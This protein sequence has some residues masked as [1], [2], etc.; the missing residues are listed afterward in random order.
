MQ[1]QTETIQTRPGYSI[2]L[3]AY[4]GDVTRAFWH[5]RR[6]EGSGFILFGGCLFW[7]LL[8]YVVLLWYAVKAV[9]YGIVILVLVL[10]QGLVM[11]GETPRVIMQR[12]AQK[13][14]P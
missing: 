7:L 9:V 14:R 1:A 10:A 6:R 2:F 13:R 3:G 12:R 5:P 8:W 11:L 4:A